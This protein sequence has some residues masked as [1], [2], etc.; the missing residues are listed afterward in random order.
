MKPPGKR[1]RAIT[2]PPPVED[3]S[4]RTLPGDLVLEIVSRADAATIVRSAACCKPLRRDILSPGFIRRVRQHPGAAACVLGFLH[5][6]DKAVREPR[7]PALF[8][9]L[10]PASLSENRVVPLLSRGAAADVLGRYVPVTSRRGLLLLRRR[11]IHHC[12][13]TDI[14]VYDPFTG[15]RAFFPRPPDLIYGDIHKYALLTAADGIG[16]AF[17][18]VAADFINLGSSC[19]I[20]VQT[21]SSAAA[22]RKWGPLMTFTHPFSPEYSLYPCCGAVVLGTLIHW[23][24]YGGNDSVIL[25]YRVGATAVGS[26]ELPAA[27]CSPSGYGGFNLHLTSCTDDM[28]RLLVS[29]GYT[30]SIWLL[31]STGWERQAVIDVTPLVPKLPQRWPEPDMVIKFKSAGGRSGAVLLQACT[32]SYLERD[33]EYRSILLDMETKETR[34]RE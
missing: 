7:P 30:V 20:K 12:W 25:T 16:C 15:D 26:I 13:N 2:E 27:P 33:H 28:L 11:H 29:D 3:T 1:L 14:C 9:L 31:L 24:M 10:H 18:L 22:D 34:R 17:L 32:I 4:A 19:S 8:S 23:L 6:Y 21:V 5:A